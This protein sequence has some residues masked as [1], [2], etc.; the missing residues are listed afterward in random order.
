MAYN[1]K[2]GKQQ[3]GDVQFEGDPTDTQI[4]F[5][6][7]FV[8]IKTNAQ[9]RFI[10]SGSFIKARAPLSCSVGISAGSFDGDSLTI[11][12]STIVTVAKQLQNIASLDATTEAT[13]EGAID[14][15]ANLGSMGGSGAELE[16]LGSLDIAQGLKI[17]NVNFVD[18]SRNITGSGLLTTL[19]GV[20]LD[21]GARIGVAG[22]TDLMTLTA[23]TVDIS[24]RVNFD[25]MLS[26]AWASTISAAQITASLGITGSALYTDSTTIDTT[27]LS[28][29]LNISGS[30]FYGDG[31]RL[32]GIASGI[33]FNG[34]TANG[35]LTYGN[36][37]TA[38]V[39]SA[40]TFVPG[41]G[42]NSLLRINGRVSASNTLEAAGNTV[43]GGT[44]AVS[45]N[46]NIGGPNQANSPLYVKAASDNSVVSI[47]KSP[48]D[49]CIL[50]V[51]GSGQVVVGG[52]YTGAKLNVTGTESDMLIQ[53]KSYGANPIFYVSGSGEL[54][55]SGSV[56]L[57]TRNPT[58]HFSSSLDA[59]VK[60][61]IGLNSADNI[62]IQN[63]TVNKHIVFKTSDAG[64]LREGFRLDG[65]VPEVVVN[66]TSD[67][68]VDFRVESDNQTHM[69]YVEGT[70]DKVGINTNEPTHTFSVNGATSISGSTAPTALEVTGASN[71]KLILARSD[72]T[73]PAFYVSGS[74]DVFI[75]G[76]LRTKQFNSTIHNF[77]NTGLAAYYIPFMST[78]E[79]VSPTYLDHMIAPADGRLVKALIR[80]DGTQSGSVVLDVHATNA[81]QETI[82]GSPNV[83]RVTRTVTHRNNTYVFPTSGSLHFSEGDIVGVRIDPHAS[84][85]NVN[86]TCVW[87]YDYRFA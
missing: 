48:S 74:G 85:S 68:L 3:S 16:A 43:L 31:S 38:D 70:A 30:R 86:V 69:L 51:T 53:A 33:G 2:K 56:T 87:E 12:G 76:S 66:Q 17:N 77:N 4:D 62:L 49:D 61:Q 9:Q 19:A 10:V 52:V 37:T 34:S 45:G 54:W 18:A 32:S 41:L 21:A 6:N 67:S 58:I 1:T 47:F 40:L 63:N 64:T 26:G 24:G 81:W 75:S 23:N 80:I 22:D 29:S 50:A 39:E 8:A 36:S 20:T 14:T 73:D 84:S 83:E 28:S 35:L 71:S 79:A 42:E 46:V 5:E 55:N 57:K 82:Q 65:A 60:A 27:H 11:G 59:A 13:I 15:L 78:V 7:D 25:T 72:M 44:M